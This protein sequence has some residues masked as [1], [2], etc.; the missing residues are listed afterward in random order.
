[1]PATGGTS[2]Q[3]VVI[4]VIGLPPEKKAAAALWAAAAELLQTT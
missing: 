3:P 2:G 4:G 1:V